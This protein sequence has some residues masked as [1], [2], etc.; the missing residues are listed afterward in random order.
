[1][2]KRMEYKAVYTHAILFP[3]TPSSV[4]IYGVIYGFPLIPFNPFP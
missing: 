3:P 4:S 2:S 1:M